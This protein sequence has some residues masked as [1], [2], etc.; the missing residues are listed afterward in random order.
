ML[1]ALGVVIVIAVSIAVVV[2]AVLQGREEIAAPGSR[3]VIFLLVTGALSLASG[4]GAQCVLPAPPSTGVPDTT[5]DAMAVQNGP[6]WTGADGTY[7]LALPNGNSLWLWSD[8]YIGTVDPATRLR[9]SYLFQ[10][11]NSLTIRDAVTGAVTTVAYPPKATSYFIPRN[12]AD[13]YWVGGATLVQPRP[14][15]YQIKVMLLEWTGVFVF[16]GNSVATLNYPSMS[17]ASIQPVALPDLSIEWGTR[18]FQDGSYYY[19]YGIKDPG[20]ANKL[21]YVARMTSLQYLTQPRGWQYW[22]ATQNAWVMGQSNATAMAGVPAITNEFSVDKVNASAGP[23]Y[24][25]VGMD[26]ANPAYP[27]WQNVISFYSCSP[28]GPW[29]NEKVVYQTPE[30]GA[31]GCSVGTLVAYNPKAHI[32][33]T[34]STGILVSYNVN[35]NNSQDLVCA[36]D[37]MPRFVRIQIPGVSSADL[38]HSPTLQTAP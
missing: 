12:K 4:L 38:L 28:Q 35:A 25:M 27:L 13:W 17:I 15:V 10:A 32:E 8:S 18:I 21:P 19:I 37:Y 26:P 16:K 20:T 1:L 14:G 3:V 2:S 29:S 6:G 36:N 22:N 7:S 31:S 30:S 33:F 9:S 23:F 34:D 24:L 11:H 5:Y